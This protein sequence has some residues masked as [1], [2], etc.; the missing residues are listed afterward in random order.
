MAPENSETNSEINLD[1]SENK[2]IEDPVSIEEPVSQEQQQDPQ[3]QPN[4]T[5]IEQEV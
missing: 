5:D 2:I 1:A 4:K 3:D